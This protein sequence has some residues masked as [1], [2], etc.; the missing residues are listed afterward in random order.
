MSFVITFF[1]S[2]NAMGQANFLT[3]FGN[4]GYNNTN[5]LSCQATPAF[6]S[7]S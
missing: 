4:G 3:I 7:A 6:N 2:I 1:I 5:R